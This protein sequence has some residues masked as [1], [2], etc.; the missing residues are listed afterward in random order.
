MTMSPSFR[1]TLRSSGLAVPT[2]TL[3]FVKNWFS[4]PARMAPRIVS[5]I[6]RYWVWALERRKL[7]S[8]S[9]K[10]RDTSLTVISPTR[11]SSASTTGIVV[12]LFSFIRSQARFRDIVASRCGVGKMSISLTCVPTLGI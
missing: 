4:S 12:M 11:R 1:N 6:Q 10:T 9:M 7:S 8:V 5:A 2:S 3:P